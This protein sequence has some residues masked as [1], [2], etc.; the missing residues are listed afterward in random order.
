MVILLQ[1]FN[2]S[3][4]SLT[5]TL[6]G[7]AVLFGHTLGCTN[8]TK[9]LAHYQAGPI[10]ICYSAILIID[11][12]LILYAIWPKI[13]HLYVKIFVSDAAA[14][15]CQQS[16]LCGLSHCLIST[17]SDCCFRL[18]S[19]MK[20]LAP[21]ELFQ[22]IHMFITFQCIGTTQKSRRKKPKLT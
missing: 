21:L 14:C 3:S 18:P 16:P 9:G 4:S 2:F 12:V 19:W 7:S 8:R 1:F 13:T 22:S 15:L 17:L 20:V 10:G 11:Y 6:I 5:G